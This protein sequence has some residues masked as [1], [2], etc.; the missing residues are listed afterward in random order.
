M[1]NVS[2]TGKEEIYNATSP[3]TFGKSVESQAQ[4]QDAAAEASPDVGQELLN[5]YRLEPIAKPDDPRWANAPGHG[6]VVVAARTPGDARIVAA[7]RELDFMEVDAAPA[8]DVTTAN[9]S[10][11]R[12]DK[13]YTVIEIDRNRRDLKRGILDGTVSIDTI[14][15]VEPD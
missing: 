14:R 12:D 9:A 11:F 4:M 1:S 7:A 15:P 6:I 3:T 13:L 5:I 10:A 2:R 8:E